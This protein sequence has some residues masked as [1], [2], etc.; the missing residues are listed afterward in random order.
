MS[1]IV[2]K[3]KRTKSATSPAS[4]AM[5][6]KSGPPEFCPPGIPGH[7]AAAILMSVERESDGACVRK[8]QKDQAERKTRTA[9]R[10]STALSERVKRDQTILCP[11]F[12]VCP[13]A[14]VFLLL[15]F[16]DLFVFPI[17]LFLRNTR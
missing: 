7:F 3:R 9:I 16:V 15:D 10:V 13:S 8:D 5:F 12:I 6:M 1:L 4:I 14:A 2:K 17:R 11:R